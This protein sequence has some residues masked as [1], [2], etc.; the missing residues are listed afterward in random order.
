MART[1]MLNH[2]VKSPCLNTE[3]VLLH[4]PLD[5]LP[6][7]WVSRSAGTTQAGIADALPRRHLL[8]VG[9]L[10]LSKLLQER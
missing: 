5:L 6:A 2:A 1:P 8:S 9:S 10:C 3:A 4:R 7:A